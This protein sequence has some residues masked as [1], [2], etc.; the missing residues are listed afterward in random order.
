MLVERQLNAEHRGMSTDYSMGR[1][2]RIGVL[3]P[4]ISVALGCAGAAFEP[5]VGIFTAALILGWTQLVGL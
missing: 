4:A 5:R 1:L 2:K 3:V